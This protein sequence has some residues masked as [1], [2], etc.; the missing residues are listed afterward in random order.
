MKLPLVNLRYPY[1]RKAKIPNPEPRLSGIPVAFQQATRLASL[2]L[3]H[4]I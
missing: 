4:E 1:K 3:F 2:L